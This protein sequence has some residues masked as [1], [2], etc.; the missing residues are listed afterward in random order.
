[1]YDMIKN[2]QIRLKNKIK[3]LDKFAVKELKRLTKNI[4]QDKVSDFP[5]QVSVEIVFFYF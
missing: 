5:W 1:M 4:W 3:N 2:W